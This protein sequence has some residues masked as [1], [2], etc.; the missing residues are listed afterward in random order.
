M[1]NRLIFSMVLV[2]GLFACLPGRASAWSQNGH[3]AVARLA[4][5]Q[6]DDKQKLA[7]T[8]ILKAHPNYDIYLKVGCPKDMNEGEWAFIKAST[9][10]DWLRGPRA[11][12]L[13][14][15]EADA[16]RDEY[17]RGVWHYVDLPLIHPNDVGKFDEA[18]I[19]KEILLPELDK[20]DQPRHALAAI[21]LSMQ[22]LTSADTSDKEKAVYLCWLSHVT[23]D[24]HQPL[25]CVSLIA[26]KDTYNPQKLDPPGGDQGGNLVGFKRTPDG[27]VTVMHAFW[28]GLVFRGQQGFASVDAK[29]TEWLRNPNFQR[30]KLPELAATDPLAWAEEGLEA[31]KNVAYKGDDG[32]LKLAVIGKGN[33]G[34]PNAKDV[35]V[36]PKDYERIAD[37]TATRRMV[38]AG[39]RF[40]DVLKVVLGSEGK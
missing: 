21:K 28:D 23:G 18:A 19:R 2:L 40:A 26:S 6:L 8:K 4:W 29:V 31:C 33:G 7:I 32:F 16:I 14:Q 12:G 35:P 10:S 37:E 24:L 30:D 36:L 1:R 15:S 34:R 5:Q 20:K 3:Y 17:S 13:K 39:Y 27:N 9:W 11:E 25:H 38:I 22:K